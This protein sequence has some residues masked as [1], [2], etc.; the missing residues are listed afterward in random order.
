M[1]LAGETPDSIDW[2]V[3]TTGT[4]PWH[5]DSDGNCGAGTE[6]KEAWDNLVRRRTKAQIEE[7]DWSV[8]A[9]LD[10]IRDLGLGEDTLVVFTS[11]N[12]GA[13]GTVNAPLRGGKGTTWEG[14]MRE[15]ALAWWPGT[16]PAGS[17]N[18]E[19]VLTMDLLPTFAK[20]VGGAVPQDRVI[21]GRDI[22]DILLGRSDARS[23]HKASY[24]YRRH[25]LEAVRSGRWKLMRQGGELFDLDADIGETTDVSG[26]HPDVV[27]V[28]SKYFDEA[29]ADLGDGPDSC[30]RCRPVGV[31][32][33]PRLLLARPGPE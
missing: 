15:P 33:N 28:L 11:D 14:G 30:P 5:C 4:Q 1:E 21:D 17:A 12:G 6:S 18:D 25:N 2:T 22:S 23:P 19:V 32:D 7:I 16:V 24:Y 9:V 31:V 26:S 13:S 27:E 20:L 29:I 8:G 3:I 10:A